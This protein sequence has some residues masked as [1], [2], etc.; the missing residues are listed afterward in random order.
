M[1][2]ALLDSLSDN[3]TRLFKDVGCSAKDFPDFVPG[4]FGRHVLDDYVSFYL[5]HPRGVVKIYH[6]AV[7]P[8]KWFAKF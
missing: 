7:K 1:S 4:S 5:Y 8:N 3:Y 6:W 2:N